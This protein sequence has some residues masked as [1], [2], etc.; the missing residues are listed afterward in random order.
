MH[1]PI[2]DPSTRMV[3][4]PDA[5]QFIRRYVATWGDALGADDGCPGH[6]LDEVERRLG[7]TLPLAVREGYRLLGRRPDL[8]NL[9]DELLAPQRLRVE[10][11]H[12]LVYRVE[13]QG[14]AVWGVDLTDPAGDDPPGWFTG[15]DVLLCDHSRTWLWVKA[16]TAAAIDKVRHMIRANGS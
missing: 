16:R 8:T 9:Q 2:A 4:R 10:D 13:N 7:L 15:P 14:C 1:D 6:E 3:G 5:W 11:D 12:V